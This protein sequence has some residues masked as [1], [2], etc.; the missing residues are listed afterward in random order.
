MN[1]LAR[2]NNIDMYELIKQNI[3]LS[4]K[5]FIQK[6]NI[7]MTSATYSYYRLKLGKPSQ[8]RIPKEIGNYL[9]QNKNKSYIELKNDVLNRFNFEINAQ[10]YRSFTHNNAIGR[11]NYSKEQIEFLKENHFKKNITELFNEKF[12]TNYSKYAIQ[13]KLAKLSLSVIKEEKKWL[14]EHSYLSYNELKHLYNETFNTNLTRKKMMSK[15]HKKKIYCKPAQNYA[16]YLD[17]DSNNEEHLIYVPKVIST[18]YHKIKL[19]SN[20]VEL[21][22]IKLK[23]AIIKDKLNQ[24]Q[25]LNERKY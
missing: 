16:I 19:Q 5:E 24:I 2:K 7:Q 11:K 1:C 3:N 21:N 15:C 12:N 4:Y 9:K 18:I 17:G 22:K 10:I 14:Q 8:K 13:D 6:T 23:C 20:D 25:N